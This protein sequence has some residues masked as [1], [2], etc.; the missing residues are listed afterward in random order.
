MDD[1][2]TRVS[3]TSLDNNVAI[4]ALLIRLIIE[5]LRE[6][7]LLIAPEKLELAHHSWRRDGGYAPPVFV[8]NIDGT[9]IKVS[10]KD[11]IRILGVYI[12]RKLNFV[13]HVRTLTDRAMEVVSASRMLGNTVRG[14]SQKHLRTLYR[15]CVLPV[16][17]YASPVW[18]SGRTD[19]LKL[20]QKVQ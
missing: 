3:S 6:I 15:T 14:L 18:W 1:G 9:V 4:L 19:H 10:A 17:T 8:A 20:L 11:A 13:Q 16:M 5:W 2:D 12:D 7:G